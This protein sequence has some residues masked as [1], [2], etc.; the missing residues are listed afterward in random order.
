LCLKNFQ[1]SLSFNKKHENNCSYGWTR[2]SPSPAYITIPKPLIPIAGK[3]I[4]PGIADQEIEEVAFI[5]HETFGKVEEE[6]I[7]IAHKLG[8]R[9]TIYYQEALGTGHAIMCAKIH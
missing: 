3:P 6:L 1:I 9:G 5:I 7:A 2:I 4:V 8:A